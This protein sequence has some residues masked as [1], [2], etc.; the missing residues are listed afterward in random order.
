MNGKRYRIVSTLVL[1]EADSLKE[2]VEEF[3]CGFYD[4][5]TIES[6][7]EDINSVTEMERE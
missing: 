2:A 7:S 4:R 6:A 1:I 3:N 5:D